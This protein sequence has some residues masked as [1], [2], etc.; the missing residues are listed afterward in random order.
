MAAVLRFA[1]GL[2]G[3]IGAATVFFFVRPAWLGAAISFIVVLVASL[4]VNKVFRR[5]ASTEQMRAD[6][7]QR[8]RNS[9]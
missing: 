3:M 4:L 1:I 9:Y 7:A 2:C 8:T 5:L 6:L